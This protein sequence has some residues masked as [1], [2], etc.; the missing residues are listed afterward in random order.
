MTRIDLLSNPMTTAEDV[1][2]GGTSG[3][4]ERLAVGSNGNVLTVTAGAV[5]WAAPA[6]G[7]AL[8]I[9]TV[10]RTTAQSVAGSGTETAISFDTE[11]EDT[12]GAWAIGDP[13][14]IIIPAGLNGRRAIFWGAGTFAANT[15][16]NYRQLRIAVGGAALV[17]DAVQSQADLATNVTSLSVQVRSYPVT[18]ATSAEYTLLMR[19]DST[20]FGIDFGSFG[21]YTI[22]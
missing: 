14:K 10:R 6:A 2:V 17:P 1:I 19:I 22:D 8:S 3:V 21:F 4:P 20:G 13:T 9:T 11:T 18:L 7:N 15:G 16:G 12:S 5:G